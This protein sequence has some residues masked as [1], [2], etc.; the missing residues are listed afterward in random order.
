MFWNIV[1]EKKVL[2]V[3]I[4]NWKVINRT[5]FTDKVCQSSIYD[6]SQGR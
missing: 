6:A 3:S 5:L 1:I 4:F 2:T